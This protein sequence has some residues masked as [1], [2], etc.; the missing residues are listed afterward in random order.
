MI[1]L[2]LSFLTPFYPNYSDSL[3]SHS[4]QH[5]A[6]TYTVT[7]KWDLILKE[8]GTFQ[9]KYSSWDT[10][11]KRK[12]AID[13]LGSWEKINDTLILTIVAPLQPDCYVSKVRFVQSKGKLTSLT[14]TNICLPNILE[15]VK[16]FTE[17][18]F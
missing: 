8:Q 18:L 5:C 9:L 13:F 15:P 2:L 3:Y 14:T 10:R 4:E 12:P 7:S 6:V 16:Q 11:Y 1:I 17:G